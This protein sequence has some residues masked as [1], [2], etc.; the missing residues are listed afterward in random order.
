MK[1]KTFL[2]SKLIALMVAMFLVISNF[3]LAVA[4]LTK[5]QL[6]SETLKAYSTDVS[7]ANG[8]FTNPSITKNTT[9]PATNSNW[10]SIDKPETVTAGIITVDTDIA[11]D[12]KIENSYKLSKLPREYT[13]MSDKQVLMINAGSTSAMTGFRSSEVSMTGGTNYV[14]SFWAYTE[15]NAIASARL[16][17][18]STLEDSENILKIITNG[19][20]V[21]YRIYVETSSLAN[22]SA[23]VEFWLGVKDIVNSTGAVFFDNVKVTS[24]DSETFERLLLNEN[25]QTKRFMY[26]NLEKSYVTNFV[27]NP[28]FESAL[29]DSNWKLMEESNLNST[30][31][32]VHGRY[33]VETFDKTETKVNDEIENTNVYGNRYALLINNLEKGFVGYESDYFTLESKSL[34]KL[35]FLA[36]TGKIEGNISVKLNERNP[37]TNET[38]SN[39]LANPNYYANSSYEEKSFEISSISTSSYTNSYTNDWQSYSFFIKSNSLIDEEANL[40]ILVGS[41]DSGAKGYAF[42]DNFPLQKI[43]SNEYTSNSSN[44]TEVNLNQNETETKFKNSAFNLFTIEDVNASYPYKPQSWTMVSSNENGAKNGIVNTSFNNASIGVP[45]IPAINANYPNNNV[46]MIGNTSSN[47]QRYT[48]SSE[49]ISANSYVKMTLNVLTTELFNAKAGIKI[50]SNGSV[51]GEITNIDT[52]GEWKPYTLLLK[53]GYEDV[54][55]SMEL[56]LA[57]GRGYAFFDN[58]VLDD[59]LT[60]EAYESTSADKKINLAKN[61]WT[62]IPSKSTE[63]PGVY[64]PNGW[65]GSNNGGSDDGAITSG[66][67]NTTK[68]GT[69]EGYNE[70]QFDAPHHPENESPYV[71]MIKSTGDSFYTYKCDT[72][73][74]LTSGNYYKISVNVKTDR[75]SQTEENKKYKDSNET[76]AYPYGATINVDGIDATFSGIDTNGEWKLYTIYINCTTESDI[77]LELSLGGANALTSGVVY[78]SATSIEEIDSDQFIMGIAELQNSNADNILAVGNTDIEPDDEEDTDDDTTG[79]ANFNWLVVPSLITGLA[80]II[81]VVGALYR[82]NKKKSPKKVKTTS[83]V[84]DEK[85]RVEENYKIELGQ[86]KEQKFK[87]SQRQNHVAEKLNNAKAHGEDAKK[88]EDEYAEIAEKLQEN[89]KKQAEAKTKYKQKL[90]EVN[91]IKE[92]AKKRN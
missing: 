83:V 13:G 87:L 40:E 69:E 29:A 54:D 66:V 18:E 58:V 86:L 21:P 23:N 82:L 70:S 92:N 81:A 37:Y 63:I 8:D 31:Q 32:S 78:Y 91:A 60:E 47:N 71:L 55:I 4:G 85:K 38:L 35:S 7:L 72:T 24:Y 68:Y 53:A 6:F 62:N 42:F 3:G 30:A 22:V 16:S 67:I 2:K 25:T 11:T 79:G 39:G 9:L 45:N 14:V 59:S 74:K 49:T 56:S 27:E 43:T 75:L 44:G 34:Y 17:G 88:F 51:L 50:L 57:E 52:E 1:S 48:S 76:K 61:D 80:I 33:N 28:S 10:T 15:K 89:A 65:T 19:T 84:K 5:R 46:L 12:E 90:A 20:W 64:V 36:K 26:V 41:V 77:A 73:S